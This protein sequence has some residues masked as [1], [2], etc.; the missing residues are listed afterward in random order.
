MITKA[1]MA[2]IGKIFVYVGVL[3]LESIVAWWTG[4]KIGGWINESIDEVIDV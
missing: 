4:V 3:T 1:K 2:L